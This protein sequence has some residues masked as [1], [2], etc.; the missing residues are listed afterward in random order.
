MLPVA[1]G[2]NGQPPMPPADA[3]SEVTPDSSAAYALASPVP[4]V[5][6][7]WTP[8]GTPNAR[9]PSASSRTWPG[10][11]TPIVSAKTISSAPAATACSATASTRPAGTA[12]SNGQ[13][14]AA[15]TITTTRRSSA[16]ARA[17]I[18]STS[19]SDSV[20]LAFWLRRLSVSEAATL[21]WTSSSPVAARR[22]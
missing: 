6:W 7:R 9:P 17:M 2:A 16:W 21:M 15:A 4:R 8:I 12:P 3:S 18:C 14:N 1:P 10:T 19:A 20:T 5:S 13:P 11:P 22:S